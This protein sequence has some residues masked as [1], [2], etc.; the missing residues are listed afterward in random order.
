LFIPEEKVVWVE[1][2]RAESTTCAGLIVRVYQPGADTDL[3]TDRNWLFRSEHRES[4]VIQF[5]THIVIKHTD[6][7]TER[8]QANRSKHRQ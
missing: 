6:L 2:R 3:K 8:H 4:S 7:N 5:C 1:F